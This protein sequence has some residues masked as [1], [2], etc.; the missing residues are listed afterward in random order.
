MYNVCPNNGHRKITLTLKSLTSGVFFNISKKDE[1]KSDLSTCLGATQ[2]VSIS[3]P[4][5]NKKLLVLVVSSN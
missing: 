2:S 5:V 3:A 1:K 4:S